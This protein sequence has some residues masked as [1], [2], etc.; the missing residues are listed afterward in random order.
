M[1]EI[2]FAGY[3]SETDDIEMLQEMIDSRKGKELSKI[4]KETLYKEKPA[5][6]AEIFLTKFEQSR[7]KHYR[8]VTDTELLPSTADQHSTMILEH[9]EKGEEVILDLNPE[10]YEKPKDYLFFD[11]FSLYAKDSIGQKKRRPQ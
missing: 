7:A 4:T 1:V 6:N 8:K 2:E 10:K 5:D 9:Q 11:F 3:D